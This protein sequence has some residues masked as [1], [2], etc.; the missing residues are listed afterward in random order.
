VITRQL[1]G[2][3]LQISPPFT[4]TVAEIERTA[5]TLI[6]VFDAARGNRILP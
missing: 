6:E 4:V 5:E 2:L 3:S 1:C